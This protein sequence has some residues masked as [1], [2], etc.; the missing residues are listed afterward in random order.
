MALILKWAICEI[1]SDLK[2]MSDY[3]ISAGTKLDSDRRGRSEA[4]EPFENSSPPL[5]DV[6]CP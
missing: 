1:E 3:F 4:S 2:R 5:N 6:N